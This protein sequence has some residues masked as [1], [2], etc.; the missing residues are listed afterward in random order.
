MLRHLY[1]PLHKDDLTGDLLEEIQSGRST[2]WYWRQVLHATLD[3]LLQQTWNHRFAL[4][5]ALLWTVPARTLWFFA[6]GFLARHSEILG[7]IRYPDSL[8]FAI[9]LVVWLLLWAGVAVYALLFFLIRRS[10]P[11]QWLGRGFWVGPLVFMLVS[12]PTIGMAAPL[13]AGDSLLR[14]APYFL[15]TLAAVWPMRFP[16]DA[17]ST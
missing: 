1:V 14:L 13:M 11:L 7:R 5:F 16:S 9:Q 2:G 4:A 8:F 3:G 15:S 6:F 17:M 12:F 10:S